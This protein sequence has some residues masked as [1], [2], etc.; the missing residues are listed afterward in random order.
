MKR[1]FCLC[2]AFAIYAALVAGCNEGDSQTSATDSG[3]PVE[4]RAVRRDDMRQTLS[5]FGDIRAENEVRVF[6]KVPD[7]I[8]RFFVDEGDVVRKGSPIAQIVATTIEQAVRQAEA[9]LVAVK[10]QEANVLVEF[11]RLRLLRQDQAI[12]QQQYDAVATQLQATQAQVQ[13][14]EAALASARSHLRDATVTAPIFGIIGKRYY[15]A[16]DMAAPTLPLVSVV[17][18]ERVKIVFEV[19][20]EDLSKLAIGQPVTARVKSYPA[21]EF[22][23]KIEMISPVLDPATRMAEVEVLLDNPEFKLKP[24]MYA[25]ADITIGLLQE[26]IVVPRHAVIENTSMQRIAGEEVVT[27][28]Y[29]V[30]VADSSKARQRKLE[31]VY[32]N[33]ESLAVSAGIQ[34]GEMLVILGQHNLRD[35][36]TVNIVRE[37]VDPS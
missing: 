5:Y 26:V 31:V 11:E 24:G 36:M 27:K 32:M 22:T 9:V 21:Q 19:T 28:N 25:Q 23:G 34:E 16:G 6:S 17:Q 4:V 2:L 30:F 14:A 10:A 35:G 29:Y 8:E 7:R 18:M 15:E 20:E 3:V 13:Q 37:E 1:A 33:H 12:S